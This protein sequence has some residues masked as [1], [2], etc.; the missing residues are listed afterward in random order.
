MKRPLS[1]KRR[2]YLCSPTCE[3]GVNGPQRT[4]IAGDKRRARPKSAVRRPKRAPDA[5]QSGKETCSAITKGSQSGKTFSQSRK[6]P[7]SRITKGSQRG[8]TLFQSGKKPG[9]GITNA[10]QRRKTSSQR[11]KKPSQR[12]KKSFFPA[13]KSFFPVFFDISGCIETVETPVFTRF[14]VKTRPGGVTGS[15]HFS[16]FGLIK[17]RFVTTFPTYSN[18]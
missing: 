16:R 5:D 15:G 7:C 14:F 9:S 11:G 12:G 10:S 18:K 3:R 4:R 8:K 2:R 13:L 17:R 1:R 6:K